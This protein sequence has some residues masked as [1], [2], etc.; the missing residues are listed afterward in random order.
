MATKLAEGDTLVSV[1]ALTDQRNIVLQTKGGF[2]LRFAV[3]EI[4]EKKKGAGIC[5]KADQVP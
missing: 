5:R 1:T 3:D 4:P 2:F